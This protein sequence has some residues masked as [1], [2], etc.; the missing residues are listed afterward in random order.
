[1]NNDE[2]IS[3]QNPQDVASAYNTLLSLS[4]STTL[5]REVVRSVLRNSTANQA[6]DPFTASQISM[7]EQSKL[8]NKLLNDPSTSAKGMMAQ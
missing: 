2:I 3:K 7:L 1:M 6:T 5:Q 4:P 8:R